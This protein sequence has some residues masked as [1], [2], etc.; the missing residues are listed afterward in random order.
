MIPFACL[1]SLFAWMSSLAHFT[2]V[3]FQ[4]KYIEDLRKGINYFRWYEYSFSSSLMIGK[5]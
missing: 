4:K 3:F 5:L 1:V 2:V